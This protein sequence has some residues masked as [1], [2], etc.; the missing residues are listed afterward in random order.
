MMERELGRYLDP[1]ETVHHINGVKDDNRPGNLE[2]WLRPQPSGIRVEDAV[3]WAREILLATGQASPP[4]EL[5]T[6]LSSLG[7]GGN[8]TRVGAARTWGIYGRISH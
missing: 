3:A 5:R 1:D 8:R 6:K 7:G 4:T 2:L